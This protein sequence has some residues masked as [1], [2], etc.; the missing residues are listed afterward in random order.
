MHFLDFNYKLL[1]R[2]IITETIFLDTL[3]APH[4]RIKIF[5]M[6]TAGKG[7]L[8]NLQRSA[9]GWLSDL[10]VRRFS[11]PHKNKR[12]QRRSDY[13]TRH[14]RHMLYIC[15]TYVVLNICCTYVVLYICWTYVVHMLNIAFG[16][17]APPTR[18]IGPRDTSYEKRCSRGF[19][20]L[21]RRR[22]S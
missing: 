16:T 8:S 3:G 4:L 13:L 14:S 1:A 19:K 5:L 2:C 7:T 6:K 10:A 21:S 22:T 12:A 9:I 18:A 17:N 20:T 15:W 11:D